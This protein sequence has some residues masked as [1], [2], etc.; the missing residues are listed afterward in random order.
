MDNIPPRVY[1]QMQ[2]QILD[3]IC[4]RLERDAPALLDRCDPAI[5]LDRATRMY[6]EGGLSLPD[7]VHDKPALIRRILRAAVVFLMHT[8]EQQHILWMGD[9]EAAKAQVRAAAEQE[10]EGW[11]SRFERWADA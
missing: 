7:E 1:R 5:L 8:V 9:F 11:M 4:D 3:E 6:S 2:T 10:F